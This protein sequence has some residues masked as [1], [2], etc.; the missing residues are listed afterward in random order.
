[1]RG[2]PG[3]SRLRIG[4]WVHWPGAAGR[5]T[6][7]ADGWNGAAPPDGAGADGEWSEDAMATGQLPVVDPAVTGELPPVGYAAEQPWPEGLL[8]D[9]E[10]EA[11]DSAY[12]GRRRRGG[13][14]RAGAQA[15][16]RP[17]S[18]ARSGPA[19]RSRQ[20]RLRAVGSWQAARS[21]AVRGWSAIRGWPAARQRRVA[22]AAL[23]VGMV[24]VGAGVAAR[25]L[26]PEPEQRP[27]P[28]P[29]PPLGF[30]PSP[31]RGTDRQGT[32]P[33]SSPRSPN[34]SATASPSP[35]PSGAEPP[36]PLA[37]YEAEAAQPGSHGQVTSMSGASGGQVVRL[38]GRR[39]GTFVQFTGVAVAETGRYRLTIRY[40][41]DQPREATVVVNDGS[42]DSVSLPARSESD[43]IGAVTLPVRLAGGDGNTV[44]I[45][46]SGGAPVA[47]DTITISD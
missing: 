24:L 33:T 14:P 7:D 37:A 29:T 41:T 35:S 3:E 11:D 22:A 2:D 21:R 19:D 32:L 45:G 20:V 10:V 44:W 5:A 46:T 40:F 43:G 39:E 17:R 9:P 34:P 4:G 42:P 28:L 23:A 47:I 12:R 30:D 18:G 27:G 38:N 1:M 26:A 36:A 13:P 6:P 16:A 8:T 15:R 31:G 25:L